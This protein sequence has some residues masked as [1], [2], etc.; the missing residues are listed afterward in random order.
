MPKEMS[1]VFKNI[2]IK[3]HAA[4]DKAT[5]KMESAGDIKITADPDTITAMAEY[6]EEVAAHE[7]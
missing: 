3:G 6:L 2:V 4:D 1:I 5:F 7:V